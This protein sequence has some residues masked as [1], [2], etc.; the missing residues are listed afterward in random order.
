MRLLY[1]FVSIFIMG[2]CNF[3]QASAYEAP[4]K[5]GP[6]MLEVTVTIEE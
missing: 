3:L 1:L 6:I 4:P 5:T 2:T